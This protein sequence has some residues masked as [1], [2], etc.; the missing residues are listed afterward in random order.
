M[1]ALMFS[2][3]YV[4]SRRQKPDPLTLWLIWSSFQHVCFSFINSLHAP[5]QKVCVLVSL[6]GTSLFSEHTEAAPRF[7]T[8]PQVVLAGPTVVPWGQNH[9]LKQ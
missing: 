6:S 9:Q 3:Y 2:L 5:S 8:T 7:Q 4:V 1:A